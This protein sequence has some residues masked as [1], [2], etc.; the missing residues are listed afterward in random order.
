M[1]RHRKLKKNI[2][3]EEKK[4]RELSRAFPC[5]IA[6]NR[7]L[8]GCSVGRAAGYRGQNNGNMLYFLFTIPISDNERIVLLKESYDIYIHTYTYTHVDLS[9]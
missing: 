3:I 6:K 7:R 4:G 1:Q 5:A 8:V 2:M 9:M